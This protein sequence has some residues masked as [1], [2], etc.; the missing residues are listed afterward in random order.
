MAFAYC[1]CAASP[2]HRFGPLERSAS[3]L[4]IIPRA[5]RQL[6]STIAKR[7]YDVQYAVKCSFLEVYLEEVYDLLTPVTAGTPQAR[8]LQVRE[9]KERGVHVPGLIERVVTNEREVE[10]L[11]A[12]YEHQP[13]M[14]SITTCV[15]P[16]LGSICSNYAPYT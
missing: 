11:I 2:A 7:V 15:T 1:C 9:S 5:A 16:A 10:E 6:F 14:S 3:T 13:T 12:M 8:P 4:G